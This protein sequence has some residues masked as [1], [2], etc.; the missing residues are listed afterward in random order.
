M[1]GKLFDDESVLCQFL[2]SIYRLEI[3]YRYREI[4]ISCLVVSSYPGVVS[5]SSKITPSLLCR[6]R[7]YD[8]C[9]VLRLAFRP[10]TEF[11]P[12]KSLGLLC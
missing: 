6:V 3:S 11:S 1:I 10:Q 5:H 4:L 12:R 7:F 2:V 8:L 9:P